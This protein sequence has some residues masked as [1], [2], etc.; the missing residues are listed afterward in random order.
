MS[1]FIAGLIIALSTLSVSAQEKPQDKSIA[2]RTTGFQRMD[3]YVPL[4]WDAAS[5]KLM[6]EI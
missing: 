4:Y 6:M 1:R 5:G 3:G 2:A